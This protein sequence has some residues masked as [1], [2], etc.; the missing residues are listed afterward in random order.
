[1]GGRAQRNLAGTAGERAGCEGSGDIRVIV[2]QGIPINRTMQIEEIGEFDFCTMVYWGVALLFLEVP[3]HLL[4]QSRA[5][6]K[7]AWDV[8]VGFLDRDRADI[9][10]CGIQSTLRK[11][12]NVVSLH[13]RQL[14]AS[15]RYHYGR[16]LPQPGT[17]ASPSFG[18][19]GTSCVPDSFKRRIRAGWG[20]SL[21]HGVFCVR[22]YDYKRQ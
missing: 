21:S 22:L 12:Q 10:S 11:Q 2:Y 7:Q 16:T 14:F 6:E 20:T 1:V 19:S 5:R 3:V 8:L 17:S 15:S 18:I 4:D 13:H 9:Q